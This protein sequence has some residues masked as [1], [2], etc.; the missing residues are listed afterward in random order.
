MLV[1]VLLADTEKQEPAEADAHYFAVYHSIDQ[2]LNLHDFP[3][4]LYEVSRLRR[5]VGN[6]ES[7]VPVS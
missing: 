6:D 7:R 4:S 3:A 1:L 5:Q 2:F